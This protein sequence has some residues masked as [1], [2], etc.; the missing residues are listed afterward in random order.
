[1]IA[2]DLL[3]EYVDG[4]LPPATAVLVDAMQ[5]WGHLLAHVAR[6]EIEYRRLIEHHRR[7]L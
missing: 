3:I 5:W 1:M 2:D 4:K 6:C 7:R